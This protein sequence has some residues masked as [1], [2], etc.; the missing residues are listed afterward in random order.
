MFVLFYF[1]FVCLQV[2][3]YAFKFKVHCGGALGPGASGLPYY[4]TPPVTVPDVIGGLVVWWHNNTQKKKSPNQR[5]WLV[6][7]PRPIAGVPFKSVGILRTTLLLRTTS[8]HSWCNWRVSCVAAF[9]TKTKTK[10]RLPQFCSAYILVYLFFWGACC[11]SN[12]WYWFSFWDLS[13]FFSF[14]F[15]V[16]LSLQDWRKTDLKK[17]SSWRAKTLR[18]HTCKRPPIAHP[19]TLWHCTPTSNPTAPYLLIPAPTSRTLHPTILHSYLPPT[20]STRRVRNFCSIV[21]PKYSSQ[22]NFCTA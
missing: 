22:R 21:F 9:Q 12:I 20:T 1:S 8:M 18:P 7:S 2:C 14:S 10:N 13:S 3:A 6:P 16:V 5:T 15:V 11:F 19:L 4:C 17:G